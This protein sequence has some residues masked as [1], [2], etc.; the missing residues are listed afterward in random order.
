MTYTYTTQRGPRGLRAEFWRQHHYYP[1][2][3]GGHNRQTADTRMAFVDWIDSLQR[4]GQISEALA[5]RAA[6]G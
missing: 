3:P 4:D 1:R 5:Q 6:L 2:R